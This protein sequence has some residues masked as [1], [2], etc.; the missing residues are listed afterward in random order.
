M[1]GR[2]GADRSYYLQ[3]IPLNLTIIG[4]KRKY[5]VE[6]TPYKFSVLKVSYLR[7]RHAKMWWN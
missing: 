2:V 3:F 4:K 5:P 1:F 7:F 6:G